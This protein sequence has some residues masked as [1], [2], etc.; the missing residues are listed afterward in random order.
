MRQAIAKH[1]RET[2]YFWVFLG[3]F[4]FISARVPG[5]SAGRVVAE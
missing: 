1:L 5:Q 4:G 3:V 2:W